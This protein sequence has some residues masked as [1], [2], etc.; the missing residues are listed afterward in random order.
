MRRILEVPLLL[1][2]YAAVLWGSMDREAQEDDYY[3]G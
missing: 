2:T 3:E 1:V